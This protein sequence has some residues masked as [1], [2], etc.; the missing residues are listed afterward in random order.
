MAG[1][2]NLYVAEKSARS[3]YLI[4]NTPSLCIKRKNLPRKSMPKKQ[5][6]KLTLSGINKKIRL[7]A[8]FLF[9]VL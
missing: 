1:R 6:K 8:D 5:V 9:S 3:L 4:F 7:L 2:Q